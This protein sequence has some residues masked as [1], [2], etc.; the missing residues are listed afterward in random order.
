MTVAGMSGDRMVEAVDPAEAFAALA[1]PTRVD[2]LRALWEHEAT[3]A[4]FSD[5]REA[6]GMADSGQ[7]NYHLSK[8]LDRFVART[9]DGYRLTSAGKHVVGGLLA[10]AYTGEVTVDPI[11]L[12]EPCPFCGG[13]RTFRYDSERVTVDCEGCAVCVAFSAPPGVFSGYDRETVPDVAERYLRGLISQDNRG[14]CPFCEGRV[15]PHVHPSVADLDGDPPAPVDF[16]DYPLLQYTCD[17]CGESVTADVGIGLADH[18]AVVAFFHDHDVDPREVPL[19][20]FAAG[21]RQAATVRQDDPLR[22]AVTFQAGEER[23]VVVVDADFAVVATER[24]DR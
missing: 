6:V 17:R 7:F 8:L 24:S 20:R 18:P 22:V 15:R 14:I 5:L 3:P 19:V 16:E 9:D 11:A 12:D 2:I 10:G 23:L 13:D 21:R 4:S 1:D